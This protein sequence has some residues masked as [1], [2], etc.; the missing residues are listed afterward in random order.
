MRFVLGM[1]GIVSPRWP[2]A[3]DIHFR[4]QFPDGV[5]YF[6]TLSYFQEEE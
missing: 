6:Q 5:E 4:P 3:T 2:G 1:A